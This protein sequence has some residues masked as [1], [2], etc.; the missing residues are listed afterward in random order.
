M[1]LHGCGSWGWAL[2]GDQLGASG[3]G[4]G[5]PGSLEAG[6]LGQGLGGASWGEK[7]YIPVLRS[8]IPLGSSDAQQE[9]GGPCIQRA[10]LGTLTEEA[11]VLSHSL[12]FVD[13]HTVVEALRTQLGWENVVTEVQGNTELPSETLLSRFSRVRLCATP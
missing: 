9:C 13:T 7:V 4:T 3:F 1:P 10:S 2:A 5:F 6:A 8:C 11:S 12:P